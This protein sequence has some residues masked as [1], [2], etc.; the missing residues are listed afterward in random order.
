MLA[1]VIVLQASLA[2]AAPDCQTR[3]VGNV[4]DQALSVRIDQEMCSG[5]PRFLACA[6]G[7]CL[8]AKCANLAADDKADLNTVLSWTHD[9]MTELV[10][11][12]RLPPPG[13]ADV[14][15]LNLIDG[16]VTCRHR[17]VLLDALAAARQSLKPDERMD[18]GGGTLE[19]RGDAL[20]WTRGI[21]APA[22]ADCCPS[23]GDLLLTLEAK[24]HAP[25]SLAK[26]E[27]RAEP[28]PKK[29]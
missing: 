3:P 23:R 5:R 15:I 2:N 17:K 29:P 18:K 28:P 9:G 16:K 20:L 25:L 13:P 1:F 14:R 6:E 22:D 11:V 8:A 10:V 19:V 21:W 26:T 7:T 4:T 24:G 27:R 12:Y